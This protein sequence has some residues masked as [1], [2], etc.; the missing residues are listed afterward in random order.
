MQESL[1]VAHSICHTVY[2]S[3]FAQ[4][5]TT[6]KGPMANQQ[7]IVPCNTIWALLIKCRCGSTQCEFVA[8]LRQP[9]LFPHCSIPLLGWD[10][11]LPFH[12][13]YRKS[14]Y[15]DSIR[16]TSHNGEF[17]QQGEPHY[18]N[19]SVSLPLF[20]I[21][22]P[23]W[24]VLPSVSLRD[25]QKVNSCALFEVHKTWLTLQNVSIRQLSLPWSEQLLENFGCVL[26]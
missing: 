2:S 23:D 24:R 22:G 19:P 16:L 6:L 21:C 15:V 12:M 8:H 20:E 18:L 3:A 4:Q 11:R 7:T 26:L 9:L 14:R 13:H 5:F 10:A 17:V 25:G 1:W